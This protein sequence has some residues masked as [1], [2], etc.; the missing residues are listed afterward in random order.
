MSPGLQAQTHAYKAMPDE[1][2]FV[3]TSV[4]LHLPEEDLPGPPVSRVV[5]DVCGEGVND[6]REVLRDGQTLCRACASGTY[7]QA[8]P[9]GTP[10]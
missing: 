6:R 1:E 2:L 5:C 8:I 4:L 10:V 9:V 7:Y 3:A